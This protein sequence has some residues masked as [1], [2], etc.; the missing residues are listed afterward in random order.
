M[1]EITIEQ[2]ETI[3]YIFALMQ[4]TMFVC[5]IVLAFDLNRIK[6]ELIGNN[7]NARI[8]EIRKAYTFKDK[9]HLRRALKDYIW[10]VETGTYQSKIHK[11]SLQKYLK[12]ADM[13]Y[14][15]YIAGKDI[16]PDSEEKKH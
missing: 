11:D 4:L 5:I 6:S 9:D 14:P 15:E 7:T 12:M 16:F 2:I 13:E 3:T 1:E 8:Q 10:H